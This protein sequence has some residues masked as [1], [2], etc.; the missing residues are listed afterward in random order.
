MTKMMYV[1]V[2]RHLE[3]DDEYYNLSEGYLLKEGFTDVSKAQERANVLN[4]EFIEDF[5]VVDLDY[6]S[7]DTVRK[8]LLQ[9][10]V[11]F[12][13]IDEWADNYNTTFKEVFDYL[14]EN[15]FSEAVKAIL[16]EYDYVIV[17]EIVLQ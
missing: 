15:G 13:K 7:V 11:P 2:E 9:H 3:Y 17:K 6:N 1:V 14:D 8:V 16:K 4:R 5:R 12:D 10:Y